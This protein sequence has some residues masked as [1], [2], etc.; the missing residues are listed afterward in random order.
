MGRVKRPMELR[1]GA[2]KRL[3]E[4]EVPIRAH[5]DC[6][7]YA[8]CVAWFCR[9]AEG[10]GD[11]TFLLEARR[12]LEAMPDALRDALRDVSI[13]LPLHERAHTTV[14][15]GEGESL[16]LFWS[17]AAIQMRRDSKL[18]EAA[19]EFRELIKEVTA[20]YRM[21]TTET[22]LEDGQFLLVDDHR[23]L[24]GRDALPAGS[25][26]HLHRCYLLLDNP[27]IR[28]APLQPKSLSNDGEL[29]L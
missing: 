18:F 29:A 10:A 26:R 9:R 12:V 4:L 13:Y 21:P 5:N 19:L 16:R 3:L 11:R 1:T 27:V 17:F 25:Q 14:V 7:H 28:E 15:R 22:A 20:A 23:F 6:N 8:D 24:H 2:S